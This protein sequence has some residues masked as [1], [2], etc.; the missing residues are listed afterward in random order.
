LIIRRWRVGWVDTE[1]RRRAFIFDSLRS[2][3][4]TRIDLKLNKFKHAF[5]YEQIPEQYEIDEIV[6]GGNQGTEC[7]PL[8]LLRSKLIS[9]AVISQ[10]EVLCLTHQG[11]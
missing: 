10:M 5:G 7:V 9:E 2:C 1:S 8:R 4:I 11:L 6:R 3:V